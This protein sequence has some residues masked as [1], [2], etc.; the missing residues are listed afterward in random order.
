MAYAIDFAELKT[1]FTIEQ[2]AQRL[3]LVLKP[4][5]KTMRGQCP[6]CKGGNRDLCV[7]PGKGFY[8][9]GVREGGDLLQL[10]AHVRQCDVK[11]AARWL[12]G[13]TSSSGTSVPSK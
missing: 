1:R 9:W 12:D 4:S 8:C 13:G 6:A 7:T 11:D 5:G 3:R 10:I 2:V